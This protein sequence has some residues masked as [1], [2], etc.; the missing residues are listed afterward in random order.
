MSPG[1]PPFFDQDWARRTRHKN[2][3]RA[4]H[5]ALLRQEV[6][7]EDGSTLAPIPYLVSESSYEI[8]KLQPRTRP[9]EDRPFEEL[10]YATVADFEWPSVVLRIPRESR[11]LT[12]DR[13]QDD[14]RV[15]Q[16]LALAV[17]DFAVVTRSA[18]LAYPRRTVPT[19]LPEQGELHVVVSETDVV[20]V[21]DSTGYRL[22]VPIESRTYELTGLELSGTGL[23]TKDAVANAY[24]TA[25]E[26]GY[27]ETPTSGVEK[28]L[29][30]REKARYYDSSALPALLDFGA[31]DARGLLYESYLLDL[32]SDLLSVAFGSRVTSGILTEGGYVTP[33]GETGYWLPSGYA[34]FD[35]ELFYL[36][37]SVVDPFGNTTTMAYDDYAFF[38]TSV[39]DPF[40]NTVSAAHDYR[41]LGPN[42]VTDPNGNRSAARFDPRGLVVATAVMGKVGSS[43]GD[44]LAAPTSY[45]EYDLFQWGTA[46]KPA[47][48]HSYAR[49]THGDSGTR[50]LESVTYTNGS[51]GVAMVKA[52]AEP[53]GTTARWVGTGRTV[54]D[55]KGN[56]IK[57][58]EPYFSTTSGYEDEDDI[59]ATGVTPILHY[60][61]IG[62]LVRTDLPNGSYSR[63]ETSPW[64]TRAFDPN[65]TVLEDGNLWRAARLSTATPAPSAA[66]ERAR[67]L[68]E[69]HANTPTTTHFDSMGRA[70]LVVA[71][72]TDDELFET[73]TKLDIESQVLEVKD[74]LG[75]TCQTHLYSMAG[76]LLKETNIDT[77]SRWTIRDVM[78]APLRRWDSRDQ[79]FRTQM[80]SLWR[81]THLWLTPGEAAEILLQ[82]TVYG[83]DAGLTSP[84]SATTC[85]GARYPRVR[86]RGRC[87][88][89]IVDFKGNLLASS[90]SRSPTTRPSTG[91]R[92]Q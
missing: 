59:V 73:R 22:A 19:E 71:D 70:F 32:T 82:R 68:A 31:A 40:G 33:S 62:R 74:P 91:A 27:H 79:V 42:L 88:R 24:S 15:S 36:P 5:G 51:G 72:N 69:A 11:S 16:T 12:Y 90:A 7:S 56:P 66:E 17:D 4:L 84:E 49:E 35:D 83:D 85:A 43:D 54:L 86:R 13:V 6:Y 20:H 18:A 41:V 2:A 28:R 67:T 52:K 80:D 10:G 3:C 47:F 65:D 34:V 75:R 60:D 46:Q 8:R 21:D 53:V 30:Q 50:W 37:T 77:G 92:R 48:A 87:A 63:V 76:Q 89:H 29:V 14:P 39:A 55:N 78:G 23:L 61:A 25:D 64:K 38:A 57:Q 44:T 1:D 81:V 26:I 9:P 58:Y 45:V